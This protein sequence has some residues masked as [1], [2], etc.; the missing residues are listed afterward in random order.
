MQPIQHSRIQLAPYR[1]NLDLLNH[2]FRKTVRQEVAREFRPD[3]AAFKIKELVFFEL[4]D[5]R[6]M[7]A[8]HIIG[9]NLKLGLG[10][11]LRIVGQEQV[12]VRLLRVG[13]L[14]AVTHKNFAVENRTR[15]AVEDALIKLMTGAVRLPVINHRMR[16]GVL[17]AVNHVKPVNPAFRALMIH[18]HVD[19]VPR[20]RRAQIDR[21]RV[22]SR[23][24]SQFGVGRG[25]V[26]G[27][28]ALALHFEVLQMRTRA[29]PDVDDCVR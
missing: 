6:S 29:Q 8:L 13:Q 5:C 3:A 26:K 27:A 1:I 9:K 25:H 19:G 16:I 23:V 15:L 20:Q 28:R 22:V 18:H 2:L 24:C 4:A 12:L 17:L 14:R 7:R 21:G 11:H 10:V